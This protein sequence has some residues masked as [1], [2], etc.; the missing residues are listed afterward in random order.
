MNRTNLKEL[1]RRPYSRLIV[2]DEETGR[3][4][5]EMVEFS[6]CFAEGDTIEEA[7]RNLE[8]AAESWMLAV[9]ERGQ[10]IPEPTGDN[11]YS[12]KFVVRV[13]RSLHSRCALYARQEGVSL[14]QFFVYALAQHTGE[15]RGVDSCTRN[16]DS[17]V[18]QF[19]E[20]HSNNGFYNG[21][22]SNTD[23]NSGQTASTKN[24]VQCLN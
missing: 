21:N 15:R 8:E 22:I 9:I 6:G 16:F 4:T 19:F 18:K 17:T 10:E 11:E 7:A 5:A 12:G 1:L 13:P 3:F 14:N 2:S 23:I 24:S 20:T